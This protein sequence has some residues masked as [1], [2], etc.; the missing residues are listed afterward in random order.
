MSNDYTDPTEEEQQSVSKS[1][2][3]RELLTLQLLGERLVKL[4]PQQWEQFGL[5]QIMLEALEESRRIKN[6]NAMRRHVRRLGKLLRNEDAALV[7]T[8]FG[9]MD[10]EHLEDTDRFH[11]LEQWRERLLTEGDIAL[12]ALLEIAP[13]ADRQHLRQLIR[14]GRREREQAQSPAAQRKLFKYLKELDLG[15]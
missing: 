12:Q 3:K 10:N 14:A 15:G 7:Q 5:S 8:L 2:I 9:R 4:H 1:E 6:H 11:R 13:E